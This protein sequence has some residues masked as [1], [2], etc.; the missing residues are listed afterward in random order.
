MIKRSSE[1]LRAEHSCDCGQKR[2]S[3]RNQSSESYFKLIFYD[4]LVPGC[5][6][7]KDSI[8]TSD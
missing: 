5:V 8:L 4:I 7:K 1:E 2:F 6:K 3:L